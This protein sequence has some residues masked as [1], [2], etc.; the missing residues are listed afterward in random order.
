MLTGG[1]GVLFFRGC[2]SS[3][4]RYQYLWMLIFRSV[5][6]W[7]LCVSAVCVCVCEILVFVVFHIPVHIGYSVCGH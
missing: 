7:C 1:R 3:V 2:Y 5:K 4:C 6:N